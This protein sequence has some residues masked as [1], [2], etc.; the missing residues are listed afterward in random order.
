MSGIILPP[1]LTVGQKGR[2]TVSIEGRQVDRVQTVWFLNDIPLSDTSV[3]G[4]SGILVLT[5]VTRDQI[6]K[7]K[8][9]LYCCFFILV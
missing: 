6:P 7:H 9:K 4:M 5:L 3:T 8:V 2:V 1:R